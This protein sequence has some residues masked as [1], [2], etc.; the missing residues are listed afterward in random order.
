[1][2]M[3]ETTKTVKDFFF[4]LDPLWQ[5]AILDP[6]EAEYPAIWDRIDTVCDVINRQI[7]IAGLVV[8][9]W[10]NTRPKKLPNETRTGLLDGLTRDLLD[11]PSRHR[12]VSS[13]TGLSVLQWAME[14]DNVPLVAKGSLRNAE[15]MKLHRFTGGTQD[16]HHADYQQFVMEASRL[17]SFHDMVAAFLSAI[18]FLRR[19]KPI[20]GRPAFAVWHP[21]SGQDT[22]REFKL[23]PFFTYGLESDRIHLLPFWRAEPENYVYRSLVCPT[24]QD[25]RPRPPERGGPEQAH[26]WITALLS[27]SFRAL[28]ELTRIAEEYLRTHK[29]CLKDLLGEDRGRYKAF[30]NASVM[31]TWQLITELGPIVFLERSGELA[32]HV[33]REQHRGDDNAALEAIYDRAER[34]GISRRRLLAV[35]TAKLLELEIHESVSGAGLEGLLKLCKNHQNTAAEKCD[36]DLRSLSHEYKDLWTQELE[37]LLR[38]LILF[39]SSVPFLSDDGH[40]DPPREAKH[41][42]RALLRTSSG[43]DGSLNALWNKLRSVFANPGNVSALQRFTG[44]VEVVPAQRLAEVEKYFSAFVDCR[45]AMSHAQRRKTERISDPGAQQLKQSTIM[46]QSVDAFLRQLQPNDDLERPI[47]PYVLQFRA[48]TYTS[49]GLTT[50]KYSSDLGGSE[51]R[52]VVYT[53]RPIMLARAYYCL[54]R[55][56]DSMLPGH[57]REGILVNP[58]I[59][60]AD[61]IERLEAEFTGHG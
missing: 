39:Y 53:A 2:Q 34:E 46:L 33:F 20:P 26:R 57:G 40:L 42:M 28:S 49:G 10:Y 61:Q 13:G 31:G 32:E 19:V 44:R 45:N 12:V 15:I 7:V 47:Y 58:L 1:M 38:K 9:A 60:P 22:G 54:P 36:D 18:S 11:H 24:L 55:L 52:V 50:M 17:L 16:P 27:T 4:A 8:L 59:L 23:G 30:D 56:G 5:S 35:E 3:T 29:G 41:E 14:C 51:S 43:S 25:T 6:D 37:R 48:A 21:E